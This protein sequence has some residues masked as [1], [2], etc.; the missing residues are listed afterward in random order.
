MSSQSKNKS[1]C[2]RRSRTGRRG[3]PGGRGLTTSSKSWSVDD[4][5]RHRSSCSEKRRVDG[6]RQRWRPA[7]PR[8]GDRQTAGAADRRRRVRFRLR[9]RDDRRRDGFLHHYA[10]AELPNGEAIPADR[11]PETV[12]G[13]VLGAIS[14]KVHGLGDWVGGLA[15]ATRYCVMARFSYGYADVD[16]DEANCLARSAGIELGNGLSCGRTT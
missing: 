6:R 11:F 10:S 13:K 5:R 4:T 7:A 15:A 14:A 3:S 1:E 9:H 12:L 16:I 8:R 2:G